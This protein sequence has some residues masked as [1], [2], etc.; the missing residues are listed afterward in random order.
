MMT[1]H[2]FP[3]DRRWTAPTTA[4][5]R[6]HGPSL[7]SA[8]RIQPE[9]RAHPSTTVPVLR[10]MVGVVAGLREVAGGGG[11]IVGPAGTLPGA[12]GAGAPVRVAV[13]TAPSA[14]PPIPAAMIGSGRQ[15]HHRRVM[16]SRVGGCGVIW[17]VCWLSARVGSPAW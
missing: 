17:S 2:A 13:R 12:G 1:C 15:R 3:S 6:G 7:V 14:T 4:R 11:G 16:C 10:E 8:V 5:C 9:G